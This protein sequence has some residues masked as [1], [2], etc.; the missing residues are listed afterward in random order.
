[1]QFWNCSVGNRLPDIY[2]KLVLDVLDFG[3][4]KETEIV[5]GERVFFF[6]CVPI[7]G[8]GYVNLYGRDITERKHAEEEIHKLN[9]ELEQRVAERTAELEAAN[10]EMESFSYSVSH[11]LR[12]PLRAID[13]FSRILQEDYADKLDDEGKRL[14]GVVRDNSNRMAQLIDDILNLSRITRGELVREEV[15]LSALAHTVAAELQQ[16]QPDRKVELAIQD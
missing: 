13:G 10:K 4:P 15:D 12:S 14:L 5:C 7:I 8:G 16:S 9:Q 1:M 2:S 11:D 3:L 6:T